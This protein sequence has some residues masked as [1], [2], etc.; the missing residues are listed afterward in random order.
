MANCGLLIASGLSSRIDGFKPLLQYEGKSFLINIVEKLL[1]IL[2]N[3]VVVIGYNHDKLLDE[4]NKNFEKRLEQVSDRSWTINDRVKIIYNKNYNEGMFTSLQLGV[5]ELADSD[6]VLYHFI[7]QPNLPKEF[8]SDILKQKTEASNWIQ[9]LFKGVK[10]HPVLFDKNVSSKII[11]AAPSSNLREI[12]K[13]ESIRKY[14]WKCNFP[15]ILED[16]DTD[17]DYQKLISAEL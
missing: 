12:L 5:K 3:L 6:W 17:E 13:D 7:D 10:G 2:P 4:L 15:Q 16:I 8:Y 1:N 11:D 14:F 9:P